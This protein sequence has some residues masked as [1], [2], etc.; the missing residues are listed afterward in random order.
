ML[1]EAA[2]GDIESKDGTFRIVGTDRSMKLTDV[3]KGFYRPAH[4][5]AQFDVGLE[6]YYTR[7]DTKHDPNLVAF[8]FAGS[9]GRPVG[10]YLPSSENVWGSILRLQRNFC[11]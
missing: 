2:V 9:G 3:A 1:M 11:P 6:V 4:L 7:V 8:N 5:P 10:I